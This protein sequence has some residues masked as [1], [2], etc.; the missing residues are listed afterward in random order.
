MTSLFFLLGSRRLC[1]R[2]F[3][4]IELLVVIAI[5]TV[6]A[7]LLA[8]ALKG[9]RESARKAQCMSN[10]RQIGTSLLLYAG[11]NSGHLPNG[12]DGEAIRMVEGAAA[13]RSDYGVTD[14]V[15]WCPSAA[16]PK[17]VNPNGVLPWYYNAWK[18]GYMPY[19][20]IGGESVQVGSLNWYGWLPGGRFPLFS[21]SDPWKTIGPTPSI[22][23]VQNAAQRPLMWDVAY[24]EDMSQAL[25]QDVSNH[26]W[27][28]PTRS[29]HANE[30][31]SGRGINVLF[32][33]GHVEWRRLNHG[34][35]QLFF[36]DF[37]DRS[38]W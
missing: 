26:Y 24:Y 29:N 9:A 38:Y 34:F 22:L 1:R 23:Q 17:L 12:R 4:L 14:G 36:A 19:Y 16:D 33:D 10:L 13:L 8:P 18:G 25:W 5:L 27:N 32:V 28:K 35:G 3:T 2:G 15:M 11:D 21:T 30:D 7:A 20:Y 6:L 37:Y 31:G